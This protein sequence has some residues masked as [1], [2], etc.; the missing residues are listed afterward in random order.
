MITVSQSLHQLTGRNHEVDTDYLELV[1]A[2]LDTL[3]AVLKV[4]LR[5]DGGKV[6]R[7][8]VHELNRANYKFVRRSADRRVAGSG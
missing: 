1:R 5:S 4:G 8:L 7:K 2:H 3:Q 6:G